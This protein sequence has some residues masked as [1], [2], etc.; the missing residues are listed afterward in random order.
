MLVLHGDLSQLRLI[1]SHILVL[2]VF[3]HSHGNEI[4]SP[5]RLL[6]GTG[7]TTSLSTAG[8]FPGRHPILGNVKPNGLMDG[9]CVISSRRDARNASPS[10]TA[11]SSR[12]VL[13][14]LPNCMLWGKRRSSKAEAAAVRESYTDTSKNL[15]MGCTRD[16]LCSGGS[17]PP[18]GRGV[19]RWG[20]GGGGGDDGRR[21]RSGGDGDW[22][23][24]RDHFIALGATQV[25]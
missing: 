8:Y 11:R 24:G 23:E 20:W 17:G 18:R 5:L 7:T 6:A 14:F 25:H 10:A 22:R 15:N 16:E 12:P 3:G 21:K 1:T 19:G 4:D 9:A 13:A 2:Q